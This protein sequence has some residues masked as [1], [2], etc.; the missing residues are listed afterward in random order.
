MNLS[1]IQSRVRTVI[2]DS[3]AAFISNTEITE[4]ANEAQLDLAARLRILQ[5][6][7]TQ[8]DLTE[9][10]NTIALP[11]TFFEVITLR[12]GT[13]DVEFVGD[14]V[15]NSYSDGAAT[16]NHTLARIFGGNIELYPTPTSGF[17]YTLRY[18]RKPA[19][20]SGDSDIPEIPE[21][22]HI[23]LVHYARAMALMAMGEINQ[24]E[25]YFSLYEQGT[26][27]RR[28]DERTWMSTGPMAMTLQPGP[29]DVDPDAR[30]K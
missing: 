26:P 5:E 8:A 24:A 15:W 23:K 2:R 25:V 19:T 12:I 9:G 3:T 29:F 16:P 22:L 27:N 14:N 20:L 7:D 11:S 21:H 10:T 4:W 30:H 6:A 13:D 1:A 18:Y 28:G 17:E